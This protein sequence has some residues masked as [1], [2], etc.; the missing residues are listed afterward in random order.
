MNQERR[1][2]IQY[3]LEELERLT[4]KLEKL[5]EVKRKQ[6][7]G[8]ELSQEEQDIAKHSYEHLDDCMKENIAEIE[9]KL[10]ELLE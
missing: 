4:Q 10:K 6:G 7:L 3:I 1:I 9:R 8:H 2:K 5:K